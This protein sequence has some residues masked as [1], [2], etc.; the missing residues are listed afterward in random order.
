MIWLFGILACGEK[1]EDSAQ[2]EQPPSIEATLRL[3]SVTN[4]QSIP[5]IDVSSLQSSD[6]TGEDGR[7]TVMVEATQPYSV[8]ATD[9]GSM[10]HIYQGV[11]GSDNFEVVGFLVD[12]S[13][14]NTVFS[15][16][17]VS[18]SS[19]KGIV[20]VALDE[21]DLSP[22]VGASALLED[23]SEGAFVFAGSGMPE[24][25]H[26]ITQGGSSFVFFPNVEVGT[27]SVEA[28]GTENTTCIAFPNGVS[29]HSISVEA[30]A[31]SVVVFS[32]Q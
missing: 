20:V 30:D 18:Q 22:A 4:G 2:V 32:C 1:T 12:R 15:F 14:T 31:V 8:R 7:A 13:T 17:N 9:D 25:G 28:F 10:D 11:A 23:S 5:D 19:D 27:K 16:M 21:L 6:V 24:S 26:T 3:L 29:T